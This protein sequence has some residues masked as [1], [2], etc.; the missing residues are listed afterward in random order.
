MQ[1]FRD[2]YGPT[3]KAFAALDAKGQVRLEADIM[4][5]LERMNV[6]GKSSLVVPGEYLEAVVV[7]K[8]A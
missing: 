1:V 5:L 7:K 8:D 4:L 2:V 3:H 6:A